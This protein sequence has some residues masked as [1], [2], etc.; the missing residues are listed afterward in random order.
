MTPSLKIKTP[1]QLVFSLKRDLN[2]LRMRRQ[3][4]KAELMIHKLPEWQKKDLNLKV[5]DL[6]QYKHLM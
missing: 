6:R 2:R 1:S 5:E 3:I 4:R